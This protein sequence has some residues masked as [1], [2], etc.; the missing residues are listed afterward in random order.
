MKPLPTSTSTTGIIIQETT[1]SK[2]C[3]STLFQSAWCQRV[4]FT[5]SSRPCKEVTLETRDFAWLV[6][7]WWTLAETLI[8]S[9]WRKRISYTFHL[10][11]H[12]IQQGY[13]YQRKAKVICV[14]FLGIELIVRLVLRWKVQLIFF[15]RTFV[16]FFSIHLWLPFLPKFTNHA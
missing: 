7:A 11:Y 16:I 6:N 14:Y 13:L 1:T 10:P 2:G 4:T 8:I 9:V 12:W 15:L 3:T 5:V